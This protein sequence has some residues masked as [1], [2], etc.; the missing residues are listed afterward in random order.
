VIHEDDNSTTRIL[1]VSDSFAVRNGARSYYHVAET[2]DVKANSND[3]LSSGFS[4]IVGSRKFS[5]IG[6][7]DIL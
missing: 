3:L 7:V 4:D 1:R 5:R 2:C 6:V